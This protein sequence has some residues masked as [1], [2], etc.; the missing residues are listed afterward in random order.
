MS[1]ESSTPQKPSARK[2]SAEGEPCALSPFNFARFGSGSDDLGRAHLRVGAAL[3]DMISEGCD[4]FPMGRQ[5]FTC[6]AL[7][8]LR[9]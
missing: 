8:K 4:L 9:I 6:W 7:A 2:V 3:E 5:E 1:T